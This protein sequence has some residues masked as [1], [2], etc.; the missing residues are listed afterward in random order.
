MLDWTKL[1][2]LGTV[3]I[4]A[5]AFATISRRSQTPVSGLWLTGW[6]MVCIHFAA[7]VFGLLDGFP[8]DAAAFVSLTALIWAG[9]FFNWASV[10]NRDLRSSRAILAALLS[11][12]TLYAAVLIFTPKITW[13]FTLIAINFGLVPLLIGITSKDGLKHPMRKVIVGLY[14][15][16][17][18]FLLIVQ[19]SSVNGLDTALNA[20]LFTIYLSCCI[21][22]LYAYRNIGAGATVTTVGFFAWASVFVVA[23]LMA[24]VYPA[25]H[26]ESEVWNLPKYV[27][28]VGMILVLLEQQIEHNK[29]LALH[30]ELTGLPNRR[31]FQDRLAQ[32][33]ERARRSGNLTA[34]LLVDLDYF[35][36]V[37]DSVG[38]HIGDEVLREV[39]RILQGRVRR[40]DTVARTGGDEFSLVLEEPISRAEAEKI[41]RLLMER[42]KQPLEIDG[43]TFN[44]GASV[45]VAVFPEDAN[46]VDALRIAADRRMYAQ[47][48]TAHLKPFEKPIG[49]QSAQPANIA[50]ARTSA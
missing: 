26:V 8:G 47:K 19:N 13:L 24:S 30:D 4:L 15:L 11:A 18:I 23:P 20:L 25:M 46:T 22:F 40:S 6:I 2:D 39:S 50:E 3:G 29:H 44:V 7:Q 28:A 17:A 33:L 37:N 1:P 21:H 49:P 34:L 16:L 5:A 14:V 43:H 35:K 9:I 48:E 42:L 41:G 45:G 10:P 32:S 31:L 38:H 27:V 12:N 36:Q